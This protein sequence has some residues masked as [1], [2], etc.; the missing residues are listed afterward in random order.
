MI[1]AIVWQ[2]IVVWAE[3]IEIEGSA[4]NILK[5][6]SLADTD[7]DDIYQD[8]LRN[9]ANSYRFLAKNPIGCVTTTRAY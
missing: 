1:Q 4:A 6:V 8:T 7:S 2:R 9:N 3:E 5:S